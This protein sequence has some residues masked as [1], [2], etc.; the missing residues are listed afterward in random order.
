MDAGN[1]STQI[2]AGKIAQSF[3]GEA[4]SSQ[5]C[6]FRQ[7]TCG[8]FAVPQ[9]GRSMTRNTIRSEER[10]AAAYFPVNRPDPTQDAERAR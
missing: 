4:R 9:S 6:R 2:F 1:K 7:D 8:S 10:S 5:V 3:I